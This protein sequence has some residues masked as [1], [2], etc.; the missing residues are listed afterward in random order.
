MTKAANLATVLTDA[1]LRGVAGA[2]YYARSEEYFAR[3]AVR[4]VRAT[5][6][7]VVAS[8]LG[9]HRYSVRLWADQG[10][11]DWSCTCPLGEDGEVCK[12]VVAAGLA[13]LA[14][15]ESGR[16]AA[17]SREPSAIEQYLRAADKEALVRLLLE[18][19]G[20]DPDI[21]AWLLVKAQRKGFGSDRAVMQV[22][23]QALDPDGPLDYDETP[24]FV[25][26]ASQAVELLQAM[27]D[28]GDYRA[29]AQLSEYALRRAFTA[30]AEIDDPY[31]AS[32]EVI[33]CVARVH[34]R[35]C[36][37]AAL[38]AEQLA[39][40]LFSLLLEDDWGIVDVGDYRRTL[41]RDGRVRFEHNVRQEWDALR[42]LRP[43][44]RGTD[45]SGHRH[46]I[47]ALMRDIAQEK[48]TSIRWSLW[49]SVTC[50][51][52]SPSRASSRS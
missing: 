10:A 12:H 9:T 15:A 23:D 2:L 1:T 14:H 22:I 8:V 30:Y 29:A 41:G 5:P 44:S 19:A 38:P 16:M 28:A 27:L 34:A 52:Q 43:H 18:L 45:D 36:A 6:A 48:G 46:L 21:G 31:G 20:D 35:A 13:W 40:R 17:A 50:L 11:L 24:A 3:G 42:E 25:A 51:T 33:D 47:T 4:N 39:D 49:S 7:Q 37:K 26:R 32:G